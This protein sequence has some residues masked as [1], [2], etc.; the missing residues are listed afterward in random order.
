MTAPTNNLVLW[1]PGV[2]ALATLAACQGPPVAAAQDAATALAPDLRIAVKQEPALVSV[3]R[4]QDRATA[5][6][7]DG[8]TVSYEGALPEDPEVCVVSW[9]GRTHRYLAGFWGS[10]RYRRGT[11]AERA[12]IRGALTGPVGTTTSFED[13]RADLWGTVTVEHVASPM[14]Q[15]KNGPRRTVQL[16]VIR[17]DARGRPDVKR[18]TLHWIDVRTGIGLKRQTVTE[19]AGGQQSADTTWRVEQIDGANL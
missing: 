14:L 10:G 19:L 13:M 12:A 9:R 11:P 17:H 4:C 8:L 15:L 6:L 3:P 5:T 7:R 16:R 2:L 18:I 1:L